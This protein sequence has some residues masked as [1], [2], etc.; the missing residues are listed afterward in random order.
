M[1]IPLLESAAVHPSISATATSVD[2]RIRWRFAASVD[3]TPL[4]PLVAHISAQSAIEEVAYY[5]GIASRREDMVRRTLVDLL[6]R[7]IARADNRG[8]DWPVVVEDAV[9]RQDMQWLIESGCQ[10]GVATAIDVDLS[11]GTSRVETG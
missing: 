3:P 11:V 6:K 4:A 9:L 7:N 8:P 5:D 2:V 1:K 10:R